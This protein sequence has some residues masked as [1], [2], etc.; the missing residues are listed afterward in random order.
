[1]AFLPSFR[2]FVTNQLLYYL[3]RITGDDDDDDDDEHD[4]LTTNEP[5]LLQIWHK[6]STGKGDETVNFRGQEV[7][8]QKVIRCQS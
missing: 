6:R 2:L 5:I 4:I 3:E 8:G 1:L 7:K